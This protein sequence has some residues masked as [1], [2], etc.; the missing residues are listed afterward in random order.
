ME[1][2]KAGAPEHYR[3]LGRS[4]PEHYRALGR[5]AFLAAAL[6]ADRR[7]DRVARSFDFLLSISPIN[8]TEAA[9][10]FF[11]KGETKTPELRYRPLAVDPETER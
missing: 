4:A 8:G 2:S 5:S 10:A 9:E 3:A 11:A 7:L 6:D 1:S